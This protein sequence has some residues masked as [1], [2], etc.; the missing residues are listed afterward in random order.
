VAHLS[1][2]SDP[3]CL[4]LC[5]LA[6]KTLRVEVVV[7]PARAAMA[8]APTAIPAA[9]AAGAVAGARA[10]AGRGG[11]GG[12]GAA[13]GA[14]RGGRGAGAPRQSRPQKSAADLDAEMEGE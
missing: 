14:G 3:N 1:S 10:A 6:E 4:P 11:R 2:L 13:R 7:D 8:Q 12:R 5:R 9:A